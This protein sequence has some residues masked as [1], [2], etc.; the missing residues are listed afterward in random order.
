MSRRALRLIFAVA[1]ELGGRL[2]LPLFEPGEFF[3]QVQ[4]VQIQLGGAPLLLADGARLRR[5]DGLGQGRAT[6]PVVL[7][8]RPCS[9]SCLAALNTCRH[10]PQRT[11]PRATL[12]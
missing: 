11:T 8:C 12:N 1:A 5:L 4:T 3:V 6:A 2:D 9:S 7:P 10:E